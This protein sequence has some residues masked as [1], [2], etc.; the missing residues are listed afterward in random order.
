MI[1]HQATL[2]A[3]SCQLLRVPLWAPCRHI[4]YSMNWT[5]GWHFCTSLGHQMSQM[6]GLIPRWI[7][8]PHVQTE[9]KFAPF[10][11]RLEC[12]GHVLG[13]QILQAQACWRSDAGKVTLAAL[14]E[15]V[16]SSQWWGS[17]TCS[18]SPLHCPRCFSGSWPGFGP[19]LATRITRFWSSHCSSAG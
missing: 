2:S 11:P 9:I 15:S 18:P 19:Q 12:G 10:F 5:E 4:L 16:S 6:R 13:C 3:F 14:M 8:C 17:W 1:L 7:F